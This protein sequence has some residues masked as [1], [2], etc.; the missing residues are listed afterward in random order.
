M[1]RD[2]HVPKTTDN[3]ATRAEPTVISTYINDTNPI[4]MG[5]ITRLVLLFVHG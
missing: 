1:N 4:I 5:V 3:E 2:N